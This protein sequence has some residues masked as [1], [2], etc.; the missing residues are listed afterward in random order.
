MVPSSRNEPSVAHVAT[1]LGELRGVMR[2]E[3]HGRVWLHRGGPGAAVL[4]PYE[5]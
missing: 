4:C 3:R 1:G 2:L 5:D